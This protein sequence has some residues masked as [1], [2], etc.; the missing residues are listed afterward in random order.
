VA[1]LACAET[2]ISSR[3]SSGVFTN[4]APESVGG[5]I[6]H[7]YEEAIKKLDSGHGN[8]HYV[9]QSFVVQTKSKPAK[10]S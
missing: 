8:E 5:I 1:P 7:L 6:N 3:Y 2:F 9:D 10:R 4:A